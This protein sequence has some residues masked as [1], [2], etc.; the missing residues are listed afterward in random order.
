MII[1]LIN[2]I[3]YYFFYVKKSFRGFLITGLNF[4]NPMRDILYE[5]RILVNTNLFYDCKVDPRY[6]KS[7][8]AAILTGFNRHS[9]VSDAV[10]RIG[11]K[12]SID[13]TSRFLQ[14]TGLNGMI[15][16]C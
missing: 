4:Y 6:A 11:G 3:N 9:I 5:R 13:F 7:R 1:T 2:I 15:T 16:N 8:H 12:K 10:L 14:K